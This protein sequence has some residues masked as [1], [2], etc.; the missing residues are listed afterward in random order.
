MYRWASVWTGA[1]ELIDTVHVPLVSNHTERHDS[2][3]EDTVRDSAGGKYQVEV[4]VM[5][6]VEEEEEEEEGEVG[7]GS[8][9][10]GREEG[11]ERDTEREKERETQRET[12]RER[13]KEREKER[14][15]EVR[16]AEKVLKEVREELRTLGIGTGDDEV[17]PLLSLCLLAAHSCLL[18]SLHPFPFVLSSFSPSFR[19]Y[20]SSFPFQSSDHLYCFLFPP[21]ST[22]SSSSSSLFS[23]PPF[24]SSFLSS[25]SPPLSRFLFSLLL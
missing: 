2:S 24:I 23:P 19:V 13:K 8:G 10:G 6:E 21:S 18:L 12:Q 11:G 17:R 25:S 22:S 5:W 9:S 7:E 4:T 1:A 3:R 14:V 16:E 15:G 20:L